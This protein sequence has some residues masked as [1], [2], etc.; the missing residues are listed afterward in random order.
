MENKRVGGLFNSAFML[1]HRRKRHFQVALDHLVVWEQPTDLTE[2]AGVCTLFR[3]ARLASVGRGLHGSRGWGTGWR[4]R[5]FHGRRG[6]SWGVS[7]GPI[8]LS[9]PQMFSEHLFYTRS[10]GGIALGTLSLTKIAELCNTAPIMWQAASKPF[11]KITPIQ[12]LLQA[13]KRASVNS[14]VLWDGTEALGWGWG[15]G[16][17]FLRPCSS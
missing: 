5:Q 15:G 3:K 9:T 14:P 17:S 12:S 16:N 8:P 6:D 10:W 1:S 11:S 2:G 7:G 4:P 13:L